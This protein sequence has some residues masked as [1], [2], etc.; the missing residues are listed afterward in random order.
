MRK[1]RHRAWPSDSALE[2]SHA[3]HWWCYA[4]LWSFSDYVSRKARCRDDC[5]RARRERDWEREMQRYWIC[6]E[7]EARIYLPLTTSMYAIALTVLLVE[8]RDTRI[9]PTPCRGLQWGVND[10]RRRL[11]EVPR[12]VKHINYTD[13][14]HL[15]TMPSAIPLCAHFQIPSGRVSRTQERRQ[16]SPAQSLSFWPVVEE[17]CC[18]DIAAGE[19]RDTLSN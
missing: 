4:R 17:P 6:G 13:L 19:G 18:L 1:Q 11:P 2:Y 14:T 16:G 7:A 5:R 12:K 8:G 9:C 3:H 15:M 10:A